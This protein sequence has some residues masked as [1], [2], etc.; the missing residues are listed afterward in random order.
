MLTQVLIFMLVVVLPSGEVRV[1]S[2]VVTQC[3]GRAQV[4]EQAELML[5]KGD[6]VGW[7]ANC[8]RVTVVVTETK[9]S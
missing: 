7:E 2:S 4:V 1:A 9:G 6:I 8:L 3:P 5:S